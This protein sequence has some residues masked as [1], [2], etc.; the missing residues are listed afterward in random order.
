MK[1]RNHQNLPHIHYLNCH[2]TQDI[3]NQNGGSQA[4]NVLSQG[5]T[6]HD[7]AH[8]T[9]TTDKKNTLASGNAG[10]EKN[11]HQGDRKKAVTSEIFPQSGKIFWETK[12]FYKVRKKL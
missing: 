2:D 11:F 9:K 4:K 8:N 6:K 5:N 12:I 10:D 3:K 7:I 1:L